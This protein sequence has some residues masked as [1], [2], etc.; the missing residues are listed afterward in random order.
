M[1]GGEIEVVFDGIREKEL[2][3]CAKIVVARFII[4][5][6]DLILLHKIS[7]FVELGGMNE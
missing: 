5:G 7:I 4:R 3:V 2:L 1:V 6:D